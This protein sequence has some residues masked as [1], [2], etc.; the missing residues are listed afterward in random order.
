MDTLAWI[1]F[2]THE[3]CMHC[4]T[5]TRVLLFEGF[6]LWLDGRRSLLP[7]N[8]GDNNQTHR[9]VEDSKKQ[10]KLRATDISLSVSL[11]FSLSLPVC[12]QCVSSLLHELKVTELL[13]DQRVY[14]SDH[15][16]SSPQLT[17]ESEHWGPLY[18]S[19]SL[20]PSTFLSISYSLVIYSYIRQCKGIWRKENEVSPLSLYNIFTA[21]CWQWT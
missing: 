6:N 20:S 5:K 4:N 17:R 16:P 9:R 10:H 18:I 2:Q 15:W 19:C 3:N 8:H 14:Y 11:S 1:A 7:W 21:L 13:C 12:P